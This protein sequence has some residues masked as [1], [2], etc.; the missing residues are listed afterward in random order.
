MSTDEVAAEDLWLSEDAVAR[1]GLILADLQDVSSDLHANAG[2]VPRKLRRA[3]DGLRK[4][5]DEA[6]SLEVR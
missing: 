3:C 4:L 5:V 6:S 2:V 1:I